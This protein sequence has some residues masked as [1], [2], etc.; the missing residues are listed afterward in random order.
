MNRRK[1][2][3]AAALVIGA[4]ATGSAQDLA[5]PAVYR[6]GPL[7]EVPF[8]SMAVG[9]GEVMLELTVAVDGS[10]SLVRPLRITPS[11]AG[12]LI[13]AARTW[14]F[15][16]AEEIVRPADRKPGERDRR[17]V[18]SR[19]LVAAMI[20]PPTINAPT[21]GEGVQTISAA[22]P[23]TPSPLST[24][25]PPFPV[26]AY[27]PGVVMIE[28]RIDPNGTIVGTRVV[29]SAPPFDGAALDA[30][31]QWTFDPARFRGIRSSALVYVIFAFPRPVV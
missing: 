15:D 12:P 22:A 20:R 9:G 14:R 13:E 5:S 7:P 4:L 29:R 26:T 27:S 18:E 6:D 2:F 21:L 11:F 16:P 10:V 31:Q 3:G 30:A 8:E 24:T 19:V 1:T 17:P 23:E 28:L 25:M